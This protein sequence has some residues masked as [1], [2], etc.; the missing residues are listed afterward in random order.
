[1]KTLLT[2]FVLSLSFS[3]TANDFNWKKITSSTD[4]DNYYVDVSS[5]KK[6][7]NKAFF[8]RLTDYIEPTQYGKLSSIVYVE[9]NCT[10]LS[11][12][13]LQDRYYVFPMGRG[14][15]ANVI[16]EKSQWSEAKKGSVGEFLNQFVCDY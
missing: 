1:M 4:G 6:I 11:S 10:T 3:V 12:R 13:Y 14:E 15:P 7:D 5:I 9:I 2:L 16:N 8:L